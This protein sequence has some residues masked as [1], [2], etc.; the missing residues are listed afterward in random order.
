MT[1]LLEQA[2]VAISALSQ[3]EQDA[4]AHDILQK[5]KSRKISRRTLLKMP[6]ESRR[7]ILAKQA[8]QM[9]EHYQQNTEWKE[10]GAGD[11]LEYDRETK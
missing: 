4:I 7:Q 5:I 11:I 8:E 3:P 6:L 2:F 1:Q 10:I 9:L